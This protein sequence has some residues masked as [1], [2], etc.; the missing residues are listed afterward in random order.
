MYACAFSEVVMRTAISNAQSQG[1]MLYFP[2]PDLFAV[3]LQV[4]GARWSKFWWYSSQNWPTGE[5]DVLG[6][7][8]VLLTPMV[9]V[10]NDI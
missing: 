8:L 6:G 1:H 10:P 3:H 4:D 5:T 2:I 7:K 9:P